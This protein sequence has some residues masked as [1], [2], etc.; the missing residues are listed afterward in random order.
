M[1]IWSLAMNNLFVYV[2]GDHDKIF[3]DY[4]LSSYLRDEKSIELWPIKYAEKPPKLINKDIKSKY[5]YLFL[6][7]LD[8]KRY[9]CITARK[10]DRLSNYN[11]LNSSRIIIVRE[12]IESWYLAGIDTSLSQFSN[13]E[14]P[15]NTDGIDKETFDEIINEISDS[16]KDALI[17][18]A[19][20]YNLD[21]AIKRN[22]SF[23]YFLDKLDGL[24]WDYS[25]LLNV[26][27]IL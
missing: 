6:S 16:K 18:I 23:K 15:E 13:L 1:I 21:L 25:L 7:D 14:I 11:Y 8:N 3:A 4:I 10:E 27:T 17:E 22:K 9:P 12:E 24:M 19:K 20:Y 26:F 2:E 5:N